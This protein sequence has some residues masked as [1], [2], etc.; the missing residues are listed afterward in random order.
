MENKLSLSSK[1]ISSHV[2]SKNFQ[3]KSSWIGFNILGIL[4]AKEL[5]SF[6]HASSSK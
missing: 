1:S 4:N 5:Y 2:I 3:W 6:Q